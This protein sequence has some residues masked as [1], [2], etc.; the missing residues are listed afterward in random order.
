MPKS[1]IF[2]AILVL[3]L[4][5]EVE[6]NCVG[7]PYPEV[8]HPEMLEILKKQ[9]QFTIKYLEEF[10]AGNK[11]PLYPRQY[12]FNHERINQIIAEEFDHNKLGLM[13]DYQKATT[14]KLREILVD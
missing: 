9:D 1:L 3:L 10:N 8:D 12:A 5:C 14:K 7:V 13:E 2:I 6:T 11:K 4:S